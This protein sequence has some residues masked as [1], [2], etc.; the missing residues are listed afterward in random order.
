[1]KACVRVF[2]IVLPILLSLNM[3]AES[4]E[5]L[6]KRAED[7]DAAAQ[8]DLGLRYAKGEGVSKDATEAVKWWRR[9]AEQGDARAQAILG[10]MYAF[11]EGVPQNKIEAYKWLKLAAEAGESG[12][13]EVRLRV[14]A[15]MT[16]AQIGEAHR[17]VRE[18]KPKKTAISVNK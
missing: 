3:S 14:T 13:A 2:G 11:G 16:P 6:R 15:A 8:C 9:A 18:F 1:M 4:L 12:I 17:L 7:G 10:V 5:E